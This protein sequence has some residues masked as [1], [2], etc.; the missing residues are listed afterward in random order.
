MDFMV[1]LIE[2]ASSAFPVHADVSVNVDVDV[3]IG[4]ANTVFEQSEQ[5]VIHISNKGTNVLVRR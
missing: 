5:T 2:I 4:I 3:D 1:E